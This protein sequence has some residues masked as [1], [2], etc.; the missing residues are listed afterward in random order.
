MK[1]TAVK[2]ALSSVSQNQKVES[3]INRSLKDQAFATPEKVAELVQKVYFEFRVSL[4]CVISV[5]FPS[6]SRLLK[7]FVNIWP[8][9]TD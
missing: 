9:I 4:F 1:V 6:S 3:A 5:Q 8:L 2:G 7:Y